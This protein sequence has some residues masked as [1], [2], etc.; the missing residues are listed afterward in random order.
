MRPNDNLVGASFL[1]M[2][3]VYERAVGY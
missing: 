3:L 1:G 2:H